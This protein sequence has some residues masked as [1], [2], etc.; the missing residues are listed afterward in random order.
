MKLIP[1]MR[2]SG[3][4]LLLVTGLLS[5]AA[6]AQPQGTA[7][8]EAPDHLSWPQEHSD[9]RP[10]PRVRFGVL[11]NGMRYAIMKNSQPAGAASVF[12]RIAAGSMQ[13]A[14]D[15]QGLAH[16]LEHMAFQGSRNVSQGEMVRSLQ[17]LGL[18]FGGDTNAQTGDESTLYTLNPTVSDPR[19]VERCLYLL[20]EIADRLTLS[21]EAVNTER[22]VVLSEETA[23]DTPAVRSW[24]SLQSLLYDGLRSV[25]RDP[26]GKREIIE[27]ASAAKLRSF[28][29]RF[30]RP[31]RAFVIV[32]G[33]ID[34][35]AIEARVKGLFGDWA[36]TGEAGVDPD[37]G[38]IVAHPLHA[39]SFSEPSLSESSGV[40][41]V[42]PE[43]MS[44][45]GRERLRRNMI[46]RMGLQVLAR[47]FLRLAATPGSPVLRAYG[48]YGS[49]RYVGTL[50][51]LIVVPQL[52][53]WSE[54]TTLAG[55]ELRRMLEYGVQPEEIAALLRQW[56]SS[57]ED[58]VR[59]AETRD[60][61]IH[62][63]GLATMME[64]RG[65]FMSPEDY[66]VEMDGVLPK[67]TVAAVN[68][69]MREMFAK[70]PSLIF[71]T[72]PKAVGGGEAAIL[73]AWAAVSKG[74]VPAPGP[75]V[76][77]AFPYTDFGPRGEVESKV[78]LDDPGVTKIVFRNGVRLNVMSTT[79]EKE[80]VGIVVDMPGGYLDFEPTERML[81]T[82]YTQTWTRGGLGKIDLQGIRDS[83]LGQQIFWYN[84]M[85]EDGYV[86]SGQTVP[87]DL[88]TEMRILAAHLVDPAF[89]KEELQKA[90][91]SNEMADRSRRATAP[92]VLGDVIQGVLRSGDQRWVL[93]SVEVANA[94][95]PDDIRSKLMPV[96]QSRPI[97]VTMVGDITVDAAID[98]VAQTF[99]ALPRRDDSYVERP[100]ARDVKFPASAKL[101]TLTHDGRK[102]QAILYMAWPGPDQL[103]DIRAERAYELMGQ[104]I[105]NELTEILRGQGKTYS[106]GAYAGG[107]DTF[108]GFGV[109]A[110]SV[111]STPAELDG[112][113][114]SVMQ[115]ISRMKAGEITSDMIERARR[116][117]IENLDKYRK[118]NWY[119][120]GALAQLQRNPGIFGRAKSVQ[121]DLLGVTGDAMAALARQYLRDERLV[122]V[123]VVPVAKQGR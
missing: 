38:A 82:L 44:P 9:L 41:W 103:A 2:V 70:A 43:D 85:S 48:G 89:R 115:V 15:E 94:V 98:V 87:K 110:V 8:R 64:S 20:R 30:Y 60:N 40:Y 68:A 61:Q 95:T 91:A 1:R 107:S 69:A 101:L 11:P 62:A 77:V 73:K 19:A 27:R 117:F 109:M 10:D 21:Q 31:E 12:L 114:A 37:R 93:P 45:Y 54:A 122:E 121:A 59:N 113:K 88:L 111:E 71:V 51:S 90:Q 112:I 86:M 34:P 75:F 105:S 108:P 116:P 56:R 99:G 120:L 14:D 42:F 96:L 83:T 104:V 53:R 46:R 72:G 65:V 52:G 97:E 74:T 58:A 17:R 119:W 76:Q 25:K 50:G 100:G 24:K 92:D 123:R 26:I 18:S 39:G 6:Q 66:K 22:G 36:P 7:S 84:A 118:N 33:D 4:V 49:Q 3:L 102:D 35:D 55:R 16:L 13:E 106:P 80:R 57:T 29:E 47:R 63:Y 78:R 28:Y 32:V 67:I 81:D 23:S 5:G 79:Y